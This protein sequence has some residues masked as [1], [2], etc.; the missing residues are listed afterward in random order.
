[1]VLL[2]LGVALLSI[3]PAC[4]SSRSPSICMSSISVSERGLLIII[5]V[6]ILMMMGSISVSE[7][8]LIKIKVV[9]MTLNKMWCK[10]LYSGFETCFVWDPPPTHTHTNTHTAIKGP[11]AHKR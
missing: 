6:H 10:L 2:A 3:R 5:T 9:I 8:W 4:R 1:M 7:R 11:Y